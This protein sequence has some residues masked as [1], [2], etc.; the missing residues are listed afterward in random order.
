MP[1][2]FQFQI[3]IMLGIFSLK[4]DNL[5]SGLV[6]RLRQTHYCNSDQK[7]E[8]SGERRDKMSLG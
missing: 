2:I 3:I 7:Q 5:P 6:E 8:V 1:E 4:I